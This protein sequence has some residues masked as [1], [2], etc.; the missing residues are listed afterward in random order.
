MDFAEKSH[1][2]LVDYGQFSCKKFCFSFFCQYWYKY[3]IHYSQKDTLSFKLFVV[4]MLKVSI[5]LAI[6]FVSNPKETRKTAN[7]D[8]Y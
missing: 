5:F 4:Y 8:A 7:C 2:K 6:S 1:V 3:N